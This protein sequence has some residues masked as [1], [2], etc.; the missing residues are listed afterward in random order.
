MENRSLSH[1]LT[2]PLPDNRVEQQRSGVPAFLTGRKGLVLAAAVFGIIALA[3]GW[4]WFGTAAVLPLLYTL[5][6]AAMMAMCMRGNGGAGNGAD[7]AK[8]GDGSERG[9]SA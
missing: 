6:C 3:A 8:T 1:A 7:R 4:T 2:T 9:G 5:P